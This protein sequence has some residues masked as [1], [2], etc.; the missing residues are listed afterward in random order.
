MVIACLYVA[1]RII[2]EE[3]ILIG[4]YLPLT[5]AR[6]T[7][8]IGILVVFIICHCS[9]LINLESIYE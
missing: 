6:R 1:I 7:L 3:D 5:S 2:L 8:P 4:F 9:L